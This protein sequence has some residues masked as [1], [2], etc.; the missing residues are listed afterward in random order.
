VERLKEAKVKNVSLTDFD[1]VA[2]EAVKEGYIR[3]EDEKRLIAFRNNPGDESW[4][5]G[6]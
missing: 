2:R 4:I 3:P 5:K 6:V 1:T